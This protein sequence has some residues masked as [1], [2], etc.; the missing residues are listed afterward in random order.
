VV[1]IFERIAAGVPLRRL[2]KQLEAEGIPTPSQIVERRGQLP[3][4]RRVTAIW[5]KATLQRILKCPAYWGAHADYRW[6]CQ[7]VKDRPA[8]TGITR[9]RRVMRLRAGGDPARIALPAGVAP[10]LVTPELAARALAR[11]ATNH[12][13]WAGRPVADPLATIWR[14]MAYC[15]HCSSRLRTM[16][17][18]ES[19][20]ARRSARRRYHCHNTELADPETGA[21]TPCPG[22]AFTMDANL[23][24][25]QGWAD[26]LDWLSDPNNVEGLIADWLERS[27]TT[28]ASAASR[29]AAVDKTIATLRQTMHDLAHDIAEAKHE[30][31]KRT[32]RGTLDEYAA[33]LE[34]EEGKR[35]RIL[36]ENADA[37]EHAAAAASFRD[38]VRAIATEAPTFRPAEQRDTLRALGARLT[39]WKQGGQPAAWPQRYKIELYFTGFSGAAPVTLL[40]TVAKTAQAT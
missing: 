28:Q 35:A 26:V 11:L 14:G 18:R 27:A 25:P 6:D 31:S 16:R 1:L 37:G 29:L 33:Q 21:R 3:P 32:L 22:G 34:M 39:I 15:G 38:W 2:C 19:P 8:E 17:E 23:I 7:K 40:P 5:H 12:A 20:S 36:Q 30:A 9:K 10:A 4:G 13:E 24:D